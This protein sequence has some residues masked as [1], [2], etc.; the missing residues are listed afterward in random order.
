MSNCLRPHEL[1]SPWNFPGQNSGVS[2]LSL[3][4]GIFPTQGLNPGLLHCRQIIYQ[5]SHKGSPAASGVM[6]S[7]DTNFIIYSLSHPAP[8]IGSR[9]EGKTVLDFILFLFSLNG[10]VVLTSCYKLTS[11]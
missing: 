5:L 9:G 4:Q 7:V 11:S 6:K 3:L 2:S 8:P 1:Y 10:P